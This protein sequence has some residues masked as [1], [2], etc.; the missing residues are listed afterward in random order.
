MTFSPQGQQAQALLPPHHDE[1]PRQALLYQQAQ[2][3]IDGSTD[4]KTDTLLDGVLKPLW[5]AYEVAKRGRDKRS[6][7]NSIFP[8]ARSC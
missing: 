7:W 1:E 6:R 5:Q 3:A 2:A 8:N 4:D